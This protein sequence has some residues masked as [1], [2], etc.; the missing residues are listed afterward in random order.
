MKGQKHNQGNLTEV[1]LKIEQDLAKDLVTMSEN[2]GLA[3]ADILAIALKRFRASHMDYM[4][5][6]L[7][8]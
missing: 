3:Q 5:K 2:S 4:G 8:D 1:T 6:R 7:D